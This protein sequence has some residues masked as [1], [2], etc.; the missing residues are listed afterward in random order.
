MAKCTND[1]FKKFIPEKDLQERI[2]TENPVPLNLHP[3]R[4]MDELMRDLIFEK[5]AGSLEVAADSNL[6]KLQQKLLDVME[7]LSKIWTIV[8]KA[9][10][11]SFEPVEFLLPEIPT[12]LDQTVMLLGQAF[13]NISY[14]RRLKALNQITGDPRK[15]KQLLKEKNEI[16]VEET[17]FLFGERFES[18]IVRIAKSKQKSKEVFS[19]MTNKQQDFRRGGHKQNNGRGQNVKM[20]LSKNHSSQHTWKPGQQYHQNKYWP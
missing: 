16:F 11:S 1:Y 6:V 2:L 13:N 10:N 14:A 20:V 9:S 12:N 5:R 19:A 4:K 18:D 7:P 3:P 15:T 17:Q 8:E